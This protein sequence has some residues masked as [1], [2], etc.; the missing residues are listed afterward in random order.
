MAGDKAMSKGV[1]V[2]LDGATKAMLRANSPT[3]SGMPVRQPVA[4]AAGGRAASTGISPAGTAAISRAAITGQM[5]KVTLHPTFAGGGAMPDA[6]EMIYGERDAVASARGELP[7]DEHVPPV[8]D[9]LLTGSVLLATVLVP[10][11]VLNALV[12][13]VREVITELPFWA[14]IGCGTAYLAVT[15]AIALSIAAAFG[16][17]PVAHALS[18]RRERR[19]S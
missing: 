7:V 19:L 17:G 8:I 5:E 13:R 2:S 14:V 9:R 10:F 11:A 15:F 4:P 1:P 12:P 16:C 18:R 3:A 6:A